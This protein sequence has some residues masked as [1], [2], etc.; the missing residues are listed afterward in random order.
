[1]IRTMLKQVTKSR[2][3]SNQ[4][5]AVEATAK[6][7]NACLLI[8]CNVQPKEIKEAEDSIHFLNKVYFFSW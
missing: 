2:T 4:V 6:P 3:H 5:N 1:M 7:I 8:A